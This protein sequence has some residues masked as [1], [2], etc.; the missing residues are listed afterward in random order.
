MS[1]SEGRGLPTMARPRRVHA[2]ICIHVHIRY[3]WLVI[4]VSFSSSQQNIQDSH[5]VKRKGWSILMC[6]L[7]DVWLAALL[8]VC[9]SEGITSGSLWQNKLCTSC[10]RMRGKE[11][12]ISQFS[13]KACLWQPPP[14]TSESFCFLSVLPNWNQQPETASLVHR[15][16]CPKLGGVTACVPQNPATGPQK[17][18]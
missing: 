13:L 5:L 6:C 18:N 14:G 1:F 7:G 15:S 16:N 3:F 8:W 10:L 11:V 17:A 2:C 9:N 12:L 4:L